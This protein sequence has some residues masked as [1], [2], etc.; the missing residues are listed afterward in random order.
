MKK[1]ILGLLVLLIQQTTWAQDPSSIRLLA[2]DP[3]QIYTHL[4]LNGGITFADS[5]GL[6]EP[7]SWQ[8]SLNG[9]FAIKKLL[10][11]FYLPVTNVGNNQSALGDIDLYLGYQIFNSRNTF[12]SSL[13]KV[14]VIFPTSHEG[15]YVNF[16]PEPSGFFNY[17]LNYTASFRFNRK[18]GLYPNLGANYYKSVIQP[19][20]IPNSGPI[21]YPSEFTQLA[22]LGGITASYDFNRKNFLQIGGKFESGTWKTED[23][24]TALGSDKELV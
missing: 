19:T 17:Y 13:L 24:S 5:Y 14:G 18:F 16:F 6:F 8:F 23:E 3:T 15:D 10:V 1:V 9:N 2:S 4:D 21:Q 11:G 22:M 7:E 20:H 12:K